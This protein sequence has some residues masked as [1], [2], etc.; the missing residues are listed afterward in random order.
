MSNLRKAI[1]NYLD[2]LQ[3]KQKPR[4]KKLT[5]T[6]LNS[7][8]Q[9]AFKIMEN[10][11]FCERKCKANR[12]KNQKGFCQLT[13]KMVV[14][15]Y[16]EHFGEEPFFVP[17]FT[18]FFWSCNFQCQYCQNWTI[19]QKIEQGKIMTSQQLAKII[20]AHENCKNVNFVGGSPTPQLPFILKAL[21]H[22]TAN[23]PTIW[24]SNFYMSKNSM[25]LLKD[26]IDV[27][28]ADFKY[29]NDRCAERLSKVQNYTE[30]I[31]RNH[32]LAFKDAELVIRHLILPNHIECCSKPILDF[33]A[34]YFKDRVIVNIMAQY[35]PDYLAANYSEINRRITNKELEEV[36]S[37]S[38]K[39]NLNFIM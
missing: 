8:I 2:I 16:F 6:K 9:Q 19:S 10:C 11:Q 12:V 29:G 22:T 23:L 5:R 38:Q 33:I 39:L 27:Y 31:K 15:S 26:I 4:F 21:K 17:S 35:K 37:Y 34:K 30:I 7:K 3:G 24:N 32:L 14:S 13:D 1:P 25:E 18:I 28:L 20:D 36:I